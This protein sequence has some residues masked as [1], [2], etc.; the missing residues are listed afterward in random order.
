MSTQTNIGNFLK[1]DL[2]D[3]ACDILL[4]KLSK[5]NIKDREGGGYIVTT[6]NNT[7]ICPG[8][9]R[10]IKSKLYPKRIDTKKTKGCSSKEVGDRVH[11]QLYHY[12]NCSN[13][14]VC[15]CKIKT[16]K[17]NQLVKNAYLKFKEMNFTPTSSEVPIHCKKGHFCTRIDVM[18]YINKGKD[19]QRSCMIEIK[20]GYETH[21]KKDGKGVYFS[22]PFEKIYAS[23]ANIH[24]LQ[25]L[26]MSVICEKEYG[27]SFSENKVIYLRKE[28]ENC[29]VVD[30]APWWK[31]KKEKRE[32]LFNLLCK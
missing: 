26:S 5:E 3:N 31:G 18:G 24:Q 22:E 1:K 20:T 2:R 16:I 9:M 6:G 28:I 8:L 10:T 7:M 12:T 17:M 32:Q 21:L 14:G 4:S 29:K 23:S 30:A 11:R 25:L 15:N 27:V 19:D 13:S